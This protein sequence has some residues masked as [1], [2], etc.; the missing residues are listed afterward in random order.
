LVAG[1]ACAQLSSQI[2]GYNTV[3]ISEKWT[4]LGVNFE[5][6][7]GGEIS[8]QDAIPYAAGMTKGT[9][10]SLADNIQIQDGAG[11]YDVYFMCNG[12]SGKTAVPDGD[13]KWVKNGESV[14]SARTIAAG[15]AFWYLAQSYATPFAVT[16]SG[17]VLASGTALSP[18]TM[19]WK[20][21][22]NPFASDLPLNDGV[23]YTAGMTKGTGT[24]LADNIQIQDGAGGYDVYFMCNGLS[25][26]TA[27]PDG[28]GKWVKNGESV[29]TTAAIPLGKGAWYL[30]RGATGFDITVTRPYSL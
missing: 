13:G 15:T 7:S 26:K 27:V 20:H 21:I 3:T 25:G 28:D 12:L 16:V 23:P 11:G 10:T 2:V 5:N 22:A 9:G 30:R 4:I 6:V 1:L 17:Q 24:S 8:L 19:T 29:V 18:V 14:V